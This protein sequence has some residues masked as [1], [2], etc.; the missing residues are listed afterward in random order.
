MDKPITIVGH[1]ISGCVVA[2][3][4]WRK[5]IPFEIVGTSLPGEASMASSGLIAPVTGRR[6]VKA[7]NIDTYIEVSK[8]F[9][10]WTAEV[11]GKNFFKE[12]EIIRFL[13]NTEALKAWQHRSEDPEYKKYISAKKNSAIDELNRPYGILTGGYRLDTPG[14]LNST[15]EFLKQKGRLKILNERFEI[16]KDKDHVIILATGA[17]DPELGH[18]VIPNKGEALVV[19]LPLWKIPLILKDEVFVVPLYEDVYWVGSYY[20]PWPENP[21]PSEEGKQQLLQ[22]LANLNPGP[23]ELLEHLSGVRPTVDDRRPIIGPFP[24]KSKVF[25]FN[26]MGTKATSLAPYWADQL[27]LHIINGVSLPAAVSPSR[28]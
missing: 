8:E 25:L 16:K 10:S 23:V 20:K 5:N 24:G 28:Y 17:A 14:W 3:T 18:G 2:M 26:G 6:Y 1:G 4:L 15:H 22:S 7:W 21:Y 12:I 9:Y 11:L 13:S 27:I 19:R